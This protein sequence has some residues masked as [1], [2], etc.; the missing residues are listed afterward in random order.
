MSQDEPE[1]I[2][3]GTRTKVEGVVKRFS[4]KLNSVGCVEREGLTSNP[5]SDRLKTK[6]ASPEK[7]DAEVVLTLEKLLAARLG[8]EPRQTDSESAVLPLHHRAV[9]VKLRQEDDGAGDGSRTCN[10]LFTKQVLC[11]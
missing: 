5:H 7:S 1:P 11:H 3:P 2:A 4:G 6:N 10:H 8:I 9:R